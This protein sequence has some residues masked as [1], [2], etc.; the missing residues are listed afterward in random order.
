MG[1]LGAEAMPS[2]CTR[3]DVKGMNAQ[4]TLRPSPWCR[5]KYPQAP[6]LQEEFQPWQLPRPLLE[7]LL[8]GD[9]Q[10]LRG[11]G[12]YLRGLVT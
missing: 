5:T 2:L 12:L 9:T 11:P 4:R 8:A 1:Y 6:G 10:V 3:L 7:A